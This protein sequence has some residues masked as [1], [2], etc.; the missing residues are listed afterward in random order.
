MADEE[1]ASR[2]DRVRA[3]RERLEMT[4]DGVAARSQGKLQ[5]TYV[6]RI[7]GGDYAITSAQQQDGLAHAFDLSREDLQQYLD[8]ELEL[9]EVERRRR[10]SSSDTPQRDLA[11]DR[12]SVV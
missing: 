4:Q 7:E 10:T 3:L 11:A 12:K 8:G 1:K 5:R 9:D 6:V 2:G